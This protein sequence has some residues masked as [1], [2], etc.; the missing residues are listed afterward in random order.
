MTG[1]KITDS[2][3]IEVKF[4]FYLDTA[5]LTSKAFIDILP[6]TRTFNPLPHDCIV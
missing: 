4:E 5:P 3:N 6:F 2:H 1:F